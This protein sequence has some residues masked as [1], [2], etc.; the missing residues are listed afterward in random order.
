MKARGL[1]SP[2]TGDVLAMTS[3]IN[4]NAKLREQKEWFEQYQRYQYRSPS[5]DEWMAN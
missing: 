2:D 4:V 3:H 1:A 5:S